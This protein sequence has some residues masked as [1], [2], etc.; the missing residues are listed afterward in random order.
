MKNKKGIILASLMTVVSGI[1]IYL[2]KC[3]DVAPIGPAYSKVGLSTMNS[4]FRKIIGSS[5]PIIVFV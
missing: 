3:F 5:Y 2:V 1:Y 4:G